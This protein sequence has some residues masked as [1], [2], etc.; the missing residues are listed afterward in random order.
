MAIADAAVGVFLARLGLAGDADGGIQAG[1]GRHAQ[2]L[3]VQVR[4]RAPHG[5]VGKVAS[6]LTDHGERRLA[7][8]QQGGRHG[9]LRQP[10]CATRCARSSS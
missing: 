10:R 5:G 8:A 1:L 6:R 2:R 9:P 3:S 4:A 7:V